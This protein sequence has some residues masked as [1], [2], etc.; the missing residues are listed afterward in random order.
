MDEAADRRHNAT[1]RRAPPAGEKVDMRQH[2]DS[3]DQTAGPGAPGHSGQG[4]DTRFGARWER[5]LACEPGTAEAWRDKVGW[6]DLAGLRVLDA[7]C[8][9]GRFSAI[10]A[11]QGAAVTGLDIAPE[12]LRAACQNAAG[13]T[14]LRH[15]LM[16]PLPV[17]GFDAAFSVGVLHHTPDPRR[18][19]ANVAAAVRPGGRLAVWV[20]AHFPG[21]AYVREARA[22]LHALTRACPTDAL[23]AAVARHAP[24]L[25][26]L[27]D[28]A[29]HAALRAALSVN[30]SPDDTV[31]VDQTFDWH[32]PLWRSEHDAAEVEGWFRQEGFEVVPPPSPFPVTVHGRRPSA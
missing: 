17:A 20:Y 21:D 6:R 24:R 15:D 30:P 25:R 7:G 32:V 28:P 18:S 13:A 22:F 12:A 14:F 23:H 3:G 27:C 11:A 26:D 19:F 31:C 1:L 4:S 8:G 16:D 10:A 29:R 2:P 9:N 5:Q